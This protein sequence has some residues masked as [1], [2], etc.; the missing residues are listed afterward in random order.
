MSKW[1]N[2]A[3]VKEAFHCAKCTWVFNDEAGPVADALI[4]D[5]MT[6]VIPQINSLMSNGYKVLMYNGVR[7]GSSCN[8]IGNLLTIKELQ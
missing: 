1:F 3:D 6:S 4:T 2:S 7:D 5:F 8:H